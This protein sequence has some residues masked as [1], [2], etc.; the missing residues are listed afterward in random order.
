[1]AFRVTE[2]VI[3]LAPPE[4]GGEEK[5]ADACGQASCTFDS[6]TTG[7][8]TSVESD[9]CTAGVGTLSLGTLRM[10]LGVRLTCDTPKQ[11]AQGTTQAGPSSGETS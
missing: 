9:S 6:P 1:M 4:T 10:E 8:Q 7:S 3:R 5:A 11:G 2:L